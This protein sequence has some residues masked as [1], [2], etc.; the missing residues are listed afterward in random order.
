MGPITNDA[1]W[2]RQA[3]IVSQADLEAVD[4]QNRTFSTAEI[5]FTDTTLGGNLAINPPPQFTRYADVRPAKK[6]RANGSQGMGRYYSEAIDDHNQIIYMRMG[7]PAFNSMTNYFGNF[8][9]S[10]MGMLARTGRAAGWF[11]ALGRAGGFVASILSWKLLAVHMLAI[12]AK[13]VSQKPNSKFYYSKPAMPLYWNAVQT[14]VNQIAVNK[15]IVPRIGGGAGQIAMNSKY[16]FTDADTAKLHQSF[17]EMF[18]SSGSIDVYAMA[19]RAQRMA[20]RQEALFQQAF[21]ESDNADLASNIQRIYDT[22]LSNSGMDYRSYLDKWLNSSASA[23][24][25]TATNPSSDGQITSAI[26][27]AGGVTNTGSSA[28]NDIPTPSASDSATESLKDLLDPAKQSTSFMEFLKAEWDDGSAFASFRVDAT[29]AVGESFSNTVGE[30]ELANKINGLSSSARETTFTFA[31]GNIAEGGILSVAADAINAAK[32]FVRGGLDQLKLSGLAVLG[33]AAYADIPKHWQSSS[34]QLP[35]ANY[36]IQLRSPYGNPISQMMNLYVP[37]AM[38]L[39]TVLPLSTG[40]QSYT[41]PFLVELYDKG[42][43]ITRLGMVDSMTISRGVGNT[44]WTSDGNALGIEIT[45]SVVDMSSVLHM[46][47]TSGFNIG[48]AFDAVT[49]AVA[50]AVGGAV[51]GSA[52][53][54]PAGGVLAAT[55]GGAVGAATELGVFD[56]DS[57]FTDYMNTLGSVGLADL[58]YPIRRFKRNLTQKLTAFNSWRSTSHMASFA[59]D[60]LPSRLISSIY[61]GVVR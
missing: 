39:A 28:G 25:S 20:R 15:G 19:N 52:V 59:G 14:I 24:P 54:G 60:L 51:V 48:A 23:T 53:A 50:G 32:D 35:R 11:Y 12:G 18:N 26:N 40:K 9:N 2:V 61:R 13:L 58:I 27:T 46:P 56:D 10:E 31:G 55:A 45:F 41:S 5:K 42:R 8:Y 1:T 44:G 47:I 22:N 36:T 7:L 33:G 49:G 4:V 37:L 3:F 17:P 30:S 6:S 21:D 16:V 43:C 57:S 38:L 34:V 29:G